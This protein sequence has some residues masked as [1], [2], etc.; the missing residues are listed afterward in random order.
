MAY[1]YIFDNLYILSNPPQLQQTNNV[2]TTV[3]STTNFLANGGLPDTPVPITSA[4]VARAQTGSFIPDQEVPYSLTYTLS[5]QRQFRDDWSVEARAMHTR[6]IHLLT[7]NRI[8]RQAKVAPED[9]RFGLPTFI[10]APSQAQIDALALNL[11]QINARSSFVPAYE[12]AGFNE[13]NLVAFL[14]NGSSNYWGGSVQVQRRFSRGFQWTNAYTWSHLI[15]DSTAEVFSTVLS[16]RRQEDFQNLRRD[17]ADSALDRRHRFV[18]SW[19][20][21][22]PFFSDAKGWTGRLLGGFSIAG[23]YTAESGEGVTIR[24][25]NDA[26]LNGDNAGDRAILNPTGQEGVGSLVNPLLRSCPAP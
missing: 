23:T 25:G 17:R 19:V 8:N 21:D 7:Q 12:A 11:A 10:T 14:S 9:G 18:S 6:G 15:D 4:A 26:N 24:S 1:D 2:D 16:P 13:T 22:L 3:P 5:F 20:Y